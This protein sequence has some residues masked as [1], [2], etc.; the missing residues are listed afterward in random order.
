MGCAGGADGWIRRAARRTRRPG[1]PTGRWRARRHRSGC[2]RRERRRPGPEWPRGRPGAART[3]RRRRSALAAATGVAA[4]AAL[5]AGAVD[6]GGGELQRRADLVDL[7][8]EDRALLA[9]AVLVGPGLQPTLDDHA[10]AP[11]ERLG[12]VL[13]RLA[14]DGAAQ[15]H[16][17]A[18]DPLVGGLVE[19]ARGRGHREVGD[20]GARGRETQLGVV[21]EVA[22]HG[23]E[24]LA[25][26][27]VLLGCPVA[28]LCVSSRRPHRCRRHRRWE[29]L[30]H[31]ARVSE[32]P[33][34]GPW[35]GGST[36][37]DRADGRAP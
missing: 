25:C 31:R 18:V 10:H 14:P 29:V 9:L 34:A 32:R 11:L 3:C 35:S 1:R 30:I 36:R 4:P 24:G 26:H 2:R 23:D 5:A 8:L 12:D 17:L 15:E 7:D 22:D 16:G 33:G 6:L 20:R 37:S 21:G 28:V 13:R 19:V 27:A